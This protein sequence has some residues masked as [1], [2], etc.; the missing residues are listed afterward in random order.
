MTESEK[1]Q[2][3]VTNEAMAV[4]RYEILASL[5][6]RQ[7]R[8]ETGKWRHCAIYEDELQRSYPNPMAAWSCD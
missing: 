5:I 3:T 2:I 4:W 6:R 8:A 7:L 1:H